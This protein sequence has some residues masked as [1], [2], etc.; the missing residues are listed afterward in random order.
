MRRALSPIRRGATRRR[1]RRVRPVIGKITR[2]V[3]W[4]GGD[5]R[6]AV[7]EC[8]VVRRVPSARPWPRLMQVWQRCNLRVLKVPAIVL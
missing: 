7:I 2:V 3:T 4:F 8:R 1:G 6:N 5:A